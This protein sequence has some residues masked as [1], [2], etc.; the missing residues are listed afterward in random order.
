MT[1]KS[2]QFPGYQPVSLAEHYQRIDEFYRVSESFALADGRI[3]KRGS[4]EPV[5]EFLVWEFKPKTKQNAHYYARIYVA[6]LLCGNWIACYWLHMPEH[7][8][9]RYLWTHPKYQHPTRRDAILCEAQKI[10]RDCA[11]MRRDNENQNE[12]HRQTIASLQ[13]FLG[14]LD[15]PT[16]RAFAQLSLF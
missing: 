3:F 16:E 1:K 13:A 11:E 8:V 12:L 14:T 9:G 15:Q 2:N 5:T 10:L 4:I 7:G 6:E